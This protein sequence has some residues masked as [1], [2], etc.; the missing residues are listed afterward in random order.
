MSSQRDLGLIVLAG[1][2]VMTAMVCTTLLVIHADV[3]VT[4]AFGVISAGV[5]IGGVALGRLSGANPDNDI[6]ELLKMFIEEEA[7]K[8]TERLP[9]R[10]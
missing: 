8:E 4:A 6:K 2:L 9:Q 7:P 5:G 3:D 10:V 1:M